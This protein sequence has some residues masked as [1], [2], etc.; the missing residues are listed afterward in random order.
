MKN[1]FRQFLLKLNLSWLVLFLK[2]FTVA[3]PGGALAIDIFG[4][5]WFS[6]VS[7]FDGKIGINPY[8]NNFIRVQ[9]VILVAAHFTPSNFPSISWA[10]HGIHCRLRNENTSHTYRSIRRW[11][12]KFRFLLT[13]CPRWWTYL[14]KF[15]NSFRFLFFYR[16]KWKYKRNTRVVCGASQIHILR[17]K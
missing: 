10:R 17:I 4:V 5:C 7:G 6:D 11:W 8:E 1:K 12:W 13:R 9:L 15:K 16:M 14:Q 2:K 3:K